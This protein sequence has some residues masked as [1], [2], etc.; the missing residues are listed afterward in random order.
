MEALAQH[1]NSEPTPRHAPAARPRFHLADSPAAALQHADIVCA[2]TTST[3]PIFDDAD[4]RPGMHIN[5]VG[6]FKPTVRELP[7]KTIV[8][9]DVFVD[10]REAAW[11][12]AGDLI[13][14]LQDQQINRQHIRAELGELVL[15]KMSGRTHPQAITVFKSVGI[16]IQDAAAARQALAN[17]K[18]LGL[19]TSVPW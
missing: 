10:S 13:Q 18:Q 3:D 5:A 6:S 12:E 11:E 9:A 1:R 16:A 4:I 7:A 17:A 15:G 19:G 2:T 14:P 8:R